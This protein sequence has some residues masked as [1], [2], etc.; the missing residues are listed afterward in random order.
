MAMKNAKQYEPKIKKLLS[1]AKKASPEEVPPEGAVAFLIDSIL[2]ENSTA[3]EAEAAFAGIV[4]E[5]VDFN[6]LRVSPIKEIVEAM[7]RNQTRTR[8]KAQMLHQSLNEVFERSFG[9]NLN[10]LAEFNKRDIRRHFREIGLSPFAEALCSMV[11]FDVHAIPVDDALADALRLNEMVDPDADIE[12]IQGFLE[13]VIA[14]KDN[15]AAHLALREYLEKH[16][17]A[18]RAEWAKQAEQ[19]RAE[20][21]AAEEKE[22]QRKRAQAEKARKDREE[23]EKAAAEAQAKAREAIQAA[24]R[25][26]TKRK[27]KSA[28]KSTKSAGKS[29]KTAGSSGKSAGDSAKKSSSKRMK[30]AA[31]PASKS[32][33]AKK[34]T[35]SSKSKKTSKSST[36]KPKKSTKKTT[37]KTAKKTTRKKA[38]KKSAKKSARKK[39]TKKSTRKTAKKKS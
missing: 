25:G 20:R 29:T 34:K 15:Y 30:K 27:K 26:E 3:A 8:Q 14:Q 33:S 21:A 13:R 19:R 2:Q 1:G 38:P 28:A 35:A 10:Y 9:P 11:L 23:A 22:R 18:V 4:Q 12:D 31:S 37:K 39:T 36:S 7:G 6:E 16:L 5:F 17:D 32:K 24:V